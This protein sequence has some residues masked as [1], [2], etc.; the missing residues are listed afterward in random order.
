MV[1][2]VVVVVGGNGAIGDSGGG[3]VFKPLK[4]LSSHLLKWETSA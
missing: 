1:V 3:Q 2:V 4:L